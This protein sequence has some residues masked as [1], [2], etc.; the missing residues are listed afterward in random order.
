MRNGPVRQNTIFGP[1][2]KWHIGS[3]PNRID[4]L[5][6]ATVVELNGAT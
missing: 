6:I 1:A 3:I 4:E 5:R 2:S